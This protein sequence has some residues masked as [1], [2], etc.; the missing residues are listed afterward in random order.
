MTQRFRYKAVCDRSTPQ[1]IWSSDRKFVEGEADMLAELYE[2][3]VKVWKRSPRLVL[4]SSVEAPH[5][6]QRSR[7]Y[8]SEVV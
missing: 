6:Q 8:G 5:L 7:G 2:C 3:G 1:S 4:V